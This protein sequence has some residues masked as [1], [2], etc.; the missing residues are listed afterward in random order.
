MMIEGDCGYEYAAV[1]KLICAQRELS[2]T[3]FCAHT[4]QVSKVIGQ[5]F[6]SHL[7]HVV[8]Q[9]LKTSQKRHHLHYC[10]KL[11]AITTSSVITHNHSAI[12]A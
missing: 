7:P 9:R 1:S 12:L 3:K 6:H 5:S 4:N 11:R 10:S 2:S 8:A